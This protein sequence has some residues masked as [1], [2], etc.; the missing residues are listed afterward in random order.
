V[1]A[2]AAGTSLA[3]TGL[4]VSSG[5]PTLA[6]APAMLTAY[7]WSGLGVGDGWV[8]HCNWHPGPLC[9]GSDYP[10]GTDDTATI[11]VKSGGGVW[12][13]IIFDFNYQST[14][15]LDDMTIL[16]GVDFDSDHHPHTMTVDT[17]TIDATDDD[18]TVTFTGTLDYTANFPVGGP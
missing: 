18:V 1:G 12:G 9:L 2:L 13:D 16:D 6:A 11:P 3:I 10:D 4:L 7:T 8:T 14:L 5:P 17:L 15:E